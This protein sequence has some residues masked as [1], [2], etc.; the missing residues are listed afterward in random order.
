MSV[1]PIKYVYTKVVIGV[2]PQADV[3]NLILKIRK[4]PNIYKNKVKA[5]STNQILSG[6]EK[7]W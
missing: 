4:I 6:P 7:Y 3:K 1:I 2:R 5:K